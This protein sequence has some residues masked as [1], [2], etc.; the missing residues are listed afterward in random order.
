MSLQRATPSGT[1]AVASSLHQVAD[2]IKRRGLVIVLSDLFDDPTR[3]LTAIKH[4]R[5][6]KN[7]V[8]VMHILDP[9]ERSFSFGAD[10]V[11]QDMETGERLTTQPFHIERSYREAMAE[12]VSRFRRECRDQ[13]VDYVL[14]DTSMSYDTALTE[15]LSKRRAMS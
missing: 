11:F 13:S 12:F 14:L 5:H 7:E 3:V 1:T 9:L 4:F 10:A 2:R 8:I 15:Y 6:K